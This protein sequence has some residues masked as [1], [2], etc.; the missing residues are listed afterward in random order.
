MASPL[1]KALAY[2]TPHLKELMLELDFW[3]PHYLRGHLV[4]SVDGDAA[5]KSFFLC[6]R[7]EGTAGEGRCHLNLG[8]GRREQRAQGDHGFSHTSFFLNFCFK[9]ADPYDSVRP[10]LATTH[11]AT[12]TLR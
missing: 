11:D 5:H 6:P 7:L 3:Y 9:P 8:C 2:S 10:T 4:W 1:K 12:C